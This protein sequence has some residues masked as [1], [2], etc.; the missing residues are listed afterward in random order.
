MYEHDRAWQK[1]ARV[2]NTLPVVLFVFRLVF[3]KGRQGYGTTLVE[4]RGQRRMLG[5]T[6]PQPSAAMH[7]SLDLRGMIPAFIHVSDGA[8][9]TT[10]ST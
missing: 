8:S 1:R 10:H 3:S 2:P 9:Y 7:T 6:L 4:L 5:I